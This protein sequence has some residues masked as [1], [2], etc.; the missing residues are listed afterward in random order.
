MFT[1][2]IVPSHRKVLDNFH[3]AT[4]LKYILREV[5][6]V[7]RAVGLERRGRREDFEGRSDK[8]KKK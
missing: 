2:P 7:R 4:H 3:S 8:K 1:R 5:R 6:V